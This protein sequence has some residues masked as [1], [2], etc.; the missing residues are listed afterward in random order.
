MWLVGG[1]H[2]RH[3]F[4]KEGCDYLLTVTPIISCLFHNCNV[5]RCNDVTAPLV[6]CPFCYPLFL[7]SANP[8]SLFAIGR[9][10]I[11][12]RSCQKS[13]KPAPQEAVHA[14]NKIQEAA[15]IEE[16]DSTIDLEDDGTQTRQTEA[17]IKVL[18]EAGVQ[19][20]GVISFSY[21]NSTMC[22]TS[23]MYGF[24]SRTELS[25]PRLQKIP[26]ILHQKSA[27]LLLSILTST[28]NM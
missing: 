14:E 18:S 25:S 28:K 4:R 20:W 13:G 22:W 1:R 23:H 3:N 11:H 2:T 26:R 24:E 8:A 17:R 12:N 7:R 5:N 16:L 6:Y 27:E 9:T 21:Q 19:R 10:S 15:I